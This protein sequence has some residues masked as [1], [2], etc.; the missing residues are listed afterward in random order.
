MSNREMSLAEGLPLGRWTAVFAAQLSHP[1]LCN[2]YW[3]VPWRQKPI[4]VPE[5]IANGRIP[6]REKLGLGAELNVK[7]LGKCKATRVNREIASCFERSLAILGR[8]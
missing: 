4:M 7:A 6:A 3:G 5:Q 2:R 1:Q 8:Q